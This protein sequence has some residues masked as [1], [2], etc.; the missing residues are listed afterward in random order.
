MIR[1]STSIMILNFLLFWG[2]AFAL[3]FELDWRTVVGILCLLLWN[4]KPSKDNW[5]D[6]YDSH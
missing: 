4:K 6:E 2:G 3:S 1:R 5:R